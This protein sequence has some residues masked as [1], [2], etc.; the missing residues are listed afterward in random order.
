MSASTESWS[1]TPGWRQSLRHRMPG[2]KSVRVITALLL[3]SLLCSGPALAQKQTASEQSRAPLPQRM[4]ATAMRGLWKDPATGELGLPAKWNYDFAVVLK[5]IEGVWFATADGSYFKFI[6]QGLDRFVAG[7][8]EIRTYTLEDYNLDNVL[9]GRNLLSVY[10]VTG[11][12]KYRKAAARL[13]EQ[14]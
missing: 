4:A 7:D 6:Q 13:R 8:G 2:G 5:G 9:L 3:L 12:E 10:K 14:L 11:N 1:G